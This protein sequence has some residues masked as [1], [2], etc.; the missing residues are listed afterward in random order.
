MRL[1]LKFVKFLRADIVITRPEGQKDLA[2]PLP[3]GTNTAFSLQEPL[4]Q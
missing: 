3:P 2:T 4:G 1:V